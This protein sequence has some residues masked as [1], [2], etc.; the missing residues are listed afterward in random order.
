MEAASP[1]SPIEQAE[2]LERQGDLPGAEAAYRRL[3]AQAPGDAAAWAGLGKVLDQMFQ[4]GEALRAYGRALE[5]DPGNESL[6]R[7]MPPPSTDPEGLTENQLHALLPGFSLPFRLNAKARRF[8]DVDAAPNLSSVFQGDNL[9]TF[10]KSVGF[11][12]DPAFVR[13]VRRNSTC[14]DEDTRIWR[15]HTLVW[16]GRNAL[17]LPGDFVELGVLRGFM[18]GCVFDCLDFAGLP[19]R[20]FLYDTFEGLAEFDPADH[21]ENFYNSLQ[22]GYSQEGIYEH[23]RDRFAP[24]PNVIIVKGA[25]PGSLAQAAPERVSFMHVD[26]NSSKA[27]VAAL[28]FFWERL[29]PGAHIV[30]DDYGWSAFREQKRAHDAFFATKKLAVLELP[31]GQG[32]VVKPP[33]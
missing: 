26:L 18:S 22:A 14:L 27:E 16:A 33:R 7:Q 24:Y 15:V 30:L 20:F 2:A 21:S 25:V 17:N 9:I 1:P 10:Q 12:A 4:R 31:T 13:A 28:E 6:L 32:V 29:V 19:R 11:M 3:L 8:L 5:S 23:V